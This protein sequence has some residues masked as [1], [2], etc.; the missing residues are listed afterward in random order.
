MIEKTPHVGSSLSAATFAPDLRRRRGA[1]LNEGMWRNL[2]E[3][4]LQANRDEFEDYLADDP[5]E[6]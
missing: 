2:L 1:V 3:K 5:Q 6:G 4:R